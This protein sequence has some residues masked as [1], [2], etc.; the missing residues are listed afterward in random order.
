[1]GQ[2]TQT[3]ALIGMMGAGKSSIGRRLASRFGVGFHDADHAIES[4]AGR[5][6][7]SIFAEYGESAFRDCERK[8]ISRL[9]E[10]APHILA[11]GGGAFLSEATRTRLK[12]SALTIWLRAPVDILFARVRRKGNR[13]LLQ[14]ENPRETLEKLL[15]EREPTYALA[16][17]IVDSEDA[18]H[19]H[20]VEKLI[21]EL[22]AKGV[23]KP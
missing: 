3:I 17:I 13:P 9:L 5:P 8:V 21:A 4:A 1:M 7:P 14:T 16:D 15:R 23:W 11:T 18:P 10:E 22:T 2:L 19:S 12:E 20:T 6:I